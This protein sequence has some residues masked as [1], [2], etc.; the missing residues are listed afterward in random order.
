M[1]KTFVI[2]Q[3]QK[4]TEE[5]LKL[6]KSAKDKPIIFDDDCPELSP[7][8]MKSARCAVA[9]RNRYMNSKKA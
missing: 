6:L 8:L 9:N 4:P 3:G 2:K 5:Q 1:T 7:E